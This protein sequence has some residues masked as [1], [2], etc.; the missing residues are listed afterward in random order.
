MRGVIY[1]MVAFSVGS[2]SLA[3]AL[4]CAGRPLSSIMA[5]AVGLVALAALAHMVRALRESA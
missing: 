1:T 4:A 3:V 2:L 5:L